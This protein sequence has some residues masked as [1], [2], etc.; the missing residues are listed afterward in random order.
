MASVGF[1]GF[2]GGLGGPG[3]GMGGG[4]MEAQRQAA[5]A[6]LPF[7]G[8]PSELQSGVEKLLTQEPTPRPP[9]DVVFTHRRREPPGTSLRRLLTARRAQLLLTVVLVGVETLSLQ[10][11]PFLSQVAIDHGITAGSRS[12]LLLAG[13]GAVVAVVTTCLASAARVATAGRMAA[14]VMTDLRVRVFGHL[15]RLSLDFY[16]N[17][18]AGVIMSRMTSDIE[19]LQQLLQES[20]VQ[21]AI[22]GLTMIVVTVVLFSYN[23]ELAVITLLMVVPLLT[24]LSLWFRA[25]SERGYERVR[26]GV[27][28]VL[29]DLSE[30]LAGVRVITGFNRQL[31]NTVQHRNVVGTYRDAN[32]Y[33]AKVN[34]RYG[35]TTDAI[36]LLGQ[37]ALLLIGGRMVLRGEL[38]VGEL[39]AFLLYLSSFFQPIQQLVQL[40]NQYQAGRAAIVKL[41]G[42]LRIEPS[43][44]EAVAA[45]DVPPIAGQLTLDGVSFA[46]DSDSDSPVLHDLDLRIEAGETIALV[47]PTGAGKST[48]AKLVTRFYDPTAGRI[49]LDGYDLRH[50][51]IESLRRQ[52]GVVPQEPFLFNGTVRDNIAFARP[53]ATDDQLWTT[54]RRVGLTELMERLPEGIDT[55]VHERGI[56]LSSGERQLLALARAFLAHP[57]VLVLDEATSNLDLESE[58]K[59]EAA[60]DTLLEGRTALLVAHRLSTAMRADRIVVI[61]DGRIVEVGSHQELVANHGRYAEMFA[62]WMSHT[63]PTDGDRQPAPEHIVGSGHPTGHELR[64]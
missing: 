31:H 29:S 51:S 63:S 42:L 61:D 14:G 24:A 36:G 7:A 19:Q 35:P 10:S 62:A 47:G 52:L 3:G 11:A 32:D 37:A 41:D 54:I 30:S 44:P 8:I 34:A 20:L 4:A 45:E 13:F 55:P 33:T 15:Q 12:V 64:R 56:S 25:A 40:Y 22:Q 43:V 21:F 38:T 6:G 46:Y 39:T 23:T 9:D 59:I 26:D 2:G 49:L 53:E 16:V 18:K 28:G 27:A 5:R 1:G 58:T 48:V 57:R 17:E 50:V 60:L